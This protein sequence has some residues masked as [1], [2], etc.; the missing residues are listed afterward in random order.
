[1]SSL[2]GVSGA[3]A[4]SGVVGPNV[5]RSFCFK[6]ANVGNLFLSAARLFIGSLDSAIE[7][8][9]KITDIPTSVGV[10]PCINTNFTYHIGAVLANGSVITGQSQIS[11]PSAA[12]DKYLP[13]IH[14]MLLLTPFPASGTQTPVSVRSHLSAEV[15]VR[16]GLRHEMVILAHPASDEPKDSDLDLSLLSED[17]L[18]NVP[19][20]THPELKKSQLHFVKAK[21]IEPLNAPVSRVF[22]ISPYGEEICPA[23]QTRVTSAIANTDILIYSIGSLMTSVVPI[24]ILKGVGRAIANQHTQSKKLILL[25]NCCEDRETYGLTAYDYVRVICEL[26]QYSLVKSGHKLIKEWNRFVTHVF[27]MENP[28]IVVD[29]DRLLGLGIECVQVNRQAENV[30]QFGSSDLCKQL[31]L[32]VSAAAKD[33]E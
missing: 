26:A 11:H 21:H 22:Y 25:L 23:A 27:Y 7:L 30:D 13:P 6:L 31:K 16:S 1:M 9:T 32:M 8:F 15:V 20:Y 5:N 2:T 19:L 4:A 29:V 3:A 24:V 28:K 10:L 17:E 14:E 12:N 18:G 33:A